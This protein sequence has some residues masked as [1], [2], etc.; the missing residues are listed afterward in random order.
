MPRAT[1][2][3][4]NAGLDAHITEPA[5]LIEILYDPV[6]TWTTGA[7]VTWD[8]KDWERVGASVPSVDDS[9]ATIQ[10]RNDNNSG[11]A[12][13][14]NNTLRDVPVR[15]YLF[16]NG[17]AEEIFR[18]YCSDARVKKMFVT[19][20]CLPNLSQNALVPRRR[21]AAPTFNHLPK[22][23]E[24]IRWGGEYYKVEY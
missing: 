11:S 3:E 18:G 6:M 23:G 19:I 5:Y 22:P 20:E 2:T 10:I 16:Y 12:L 9:G 7:E 14:L 17:D 21:V 24:V 4:F 15:I 13:V 8:S 1:S